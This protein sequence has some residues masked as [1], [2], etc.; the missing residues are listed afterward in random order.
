[1]R[2]NGLRATAGEAPRL[3]VNRPRGPLGGSGVRVRAGLATLAWAGHAPKV[4]GTIVRVAPGVGAGSWTGPAPAVAVISGILTGYGSMTWSG[5]APTV[6][7]L[8]S[9]NAINWGANNDNFL[10][11]G[12][13]EITWGT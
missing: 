3:F 11:W 4:T 8:V 12:T 13:G 1:M 9:P 10:A 6:T 5:H 2:R 7:G